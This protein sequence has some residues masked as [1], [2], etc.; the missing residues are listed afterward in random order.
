M[1]LAVLLGCRA[2]GHIGVRETHCPL[3]RLH[4]HRLH[5]WI[6][7][8]LFRVTE[9]RIEDPAT[10]VASRPGN[11]EIVVGAVHAW[12]PQIQFGGVQAG[13]YSDPVTREVPYL[14]D[15]IARGERVRKRLH[16]WKTRILYDYWSIQDG[17]GVIVKIATDHLAVL[18]PF[19][20][21]RNRGMD[22]DESLAVFLDERQ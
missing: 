20:K 1:D 16:R 14:I 5:G 3:D 12:I 4:P 13:Q 15:L 21:G 17:P 11:R 8:R 19:I 22:A 7:P 9:G 10:T 6:V 2:W 18:G